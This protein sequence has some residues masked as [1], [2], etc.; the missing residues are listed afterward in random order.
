MHD[1]GRSSHDKDRSELNE[2]ISK[3][4]KG[5]FEF[6]EDN[7][8]MAKGDLGKSITKVDLGK[9]KA[10]MGRVKVD[11]DEEKGVAIRLVQIEFCRGKTAT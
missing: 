5:R 3:L 4:D 8:V 11:M 6:R 1:E 2:D 10:N 9:V 7:R